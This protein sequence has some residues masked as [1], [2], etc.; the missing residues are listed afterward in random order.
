MKVTKPKKRVILY[1]FVEY[2]FFFLIVSLYLISTFLKYFTLYHALTI[3]VLN[4]TIVTIVLSLLFL[5]YKWVMTEYFLLKNYLFI[6]E[7][8]TSVKIAYADI[9]DI[10]YKGNLLQHLMGT[11]N[12]RIITKKNGNYYIKGIRNYKKFEDELLA[13]MNS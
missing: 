6:K 10:E 8:G 11:T 9:K 5:L 12:M 1:W 3:Y 13:R 7:G 2:G 4:L